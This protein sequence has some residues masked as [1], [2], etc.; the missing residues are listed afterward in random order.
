MVVYRKNSFLQMHVSAQLVLFLDKLC[1]QMLVH[2]A[3]NSN[4]KRRP[5]DRIG[6]GPVT[7]P[8]GTKVAYSS[9]RH[10]PGPL[11]ITLPLFYLQHR[12]I[13]YF[14]VLHNHQVE[15]SN[16]CPTSS[17]QC[18]CQ[19]L[20]SVRTLCALRGAHSWIPS[21]SAHSHHVVHSFAHTNVQHP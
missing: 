3:A 11:P 8:S 19:G 12:S 2:R 4:R 5:Y 17:C 6:T 7:V 21:L 10:M 13:N 16:Q 14:A 1:R 18:V 15:Q 20:V 9:A